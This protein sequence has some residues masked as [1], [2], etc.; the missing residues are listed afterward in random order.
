LT[1]TDYNSISAFGGLTPSEYDSWRVDSELYKEVEQ[2]FVLGVL[3]QLAFRRAL[4]I[5][6]GTGLWTC[7]LSRLRPDSQSVGIDIDRNMVA[8]ASRICSATFKIG[9]A[10]TFRDSVAF[11]LIISAL[12]ADYIG[13]SS[14]FT[15]VAENLSNTGVAYSWLLNPQR[16]PRVGGRRTK[17]WQ[18]HGRVIQVDIPDYDVTSIPDIAA[19]RGLEC[20]ITQTDF[21]LRD[22]IPRVFVLI[23]NTL[24]TPRSS[25]V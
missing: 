25:L 16:Y 10:N 7:H 17:S 12:S 21:K 19:D 4:D 23:R 1:I 5:G 8:Y 2:P 14:F 18:V 11:D 15:A 6:C 13:L 3:R 9:D 22:N 20:H 24:R